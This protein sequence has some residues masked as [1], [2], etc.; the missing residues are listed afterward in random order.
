LPPASSLT[1][2]LSDEERR[3]AA[4][5]LSPSAIAGTLRRLRE[6]PPAMRP[7]GEQREG[8]RPRLTEETIEAAQRDE[9]AR[10]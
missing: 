7:E 3:A 9:D 2:F 1:G 6:S 10:Q 5:N 4:N 8:G